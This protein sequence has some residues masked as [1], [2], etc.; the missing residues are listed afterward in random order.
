[1]KTRSLNESFIYAISGLRETIL[2]ERNMK[3]HLLAAFFAVLLGVIF[4]L[5]R[6]EWGFLFLT[7]CIVLT[8]EMINT[9]IERTV[10]LVTD[11]YHPLAKAAKNVA[12]GA[13]FLSALIAVVMGIII[14]G[15][16]ILAVINIMKG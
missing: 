4:S 6:I 11:N 15:P 7:I 14:F 12:A 1:M 3:I 9:A 5:N 8:A 16:H 2:K 10:D 13:V